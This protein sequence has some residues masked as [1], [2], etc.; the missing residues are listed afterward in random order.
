LDRHHSI[1][2]CSRFLSL[3]C[4]CLRAR[5]IAAELGCEPAS[6]FISRWRRVKIIINA[7]PPENSPRN[8][9]A[10]LIFRR[11]P[12]AVQKNPRMKFDR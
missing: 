5:R 1:P 6:R 9:R 3:P 2:F 10:S 7:A 4:A 11:L 8:P 12:M